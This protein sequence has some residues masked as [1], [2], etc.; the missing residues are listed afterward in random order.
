M[1][2]YDS[3]GYDPPAPV[4]QVILRNISNPQSTSETSLLVDTGADITLLPRFAVEQL[5]VNPV[6]GLDCELLGF[7]GTKTRA[8]AVELD[9]IFLGKAFRGRYLLIDAD[10]G[11]MGRDVLASVALLLDGPRGEW[12]EHRTNSLH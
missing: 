4:A 2:A 7:D 9:M 12:S 10:Q 5:R 8:R 11:I 6:A 3:S 1:P